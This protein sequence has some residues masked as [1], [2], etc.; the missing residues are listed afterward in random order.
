METESRIGHKVSTAEAR[1]G[2]A[3]AGGRGRKL[4]FK[5]DADR[6]QTH[7]LDFN[8]FFVGQLLPPHSLRLTLSHAATVN[9][10]P[11]DEIFFHGHLLSNLCGRD[12]LPLIVHQLHRRH[13][14]HLHRGRPLNRPKPPLHLPIHYP[15][16][17]RPSI[18]TPNFAAR[19]PTEP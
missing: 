7:M 5:A 16:L 10:S 18:L 12:R 11:T 9:L 4:L 19:S 14:H 1:G 17:L 15:D 6:D 8:S 3:E 13:H 2:P